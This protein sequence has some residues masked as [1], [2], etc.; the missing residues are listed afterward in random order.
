MKLLKTG[1]IFLASFGLIL[2]GSC[3][4]SDK[5]A[6]SGHNSATSTSAK[7]ET[8]KESPKRQSVVTDNYHLELAS[9]KEGDN[10]YLAFYLHEQANHEKVIPNAKVIGQVQF[11]D[12]T[13]KNLDF[14]YDV[15]GQFY[16]ALLPANTAN[17]YLVKVTADVNREKVSGRFNIKQ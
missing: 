16:R 6:H 8:V 4:N 9:Q 17:Q 2:L 11:P 3:S 14:K 5:A 7:I 1:L 15:V 10:N 13:Q 12:G